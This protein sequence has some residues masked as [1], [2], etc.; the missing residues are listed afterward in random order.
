MD[1]YYLMAWYIDPPL[2]A[3]GIRK[4]FNALKEMFRLERAAYQY[5]NR[6]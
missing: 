3:A 5:L 4:R 2:K 1:G 6:L